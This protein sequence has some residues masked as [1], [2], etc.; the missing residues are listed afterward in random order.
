[1]IFLFGR[2]KK[3]KARPPVPPAPRSAPAPRRTEQDKHAAARADI[4]NT[5]TAERATLPTTHVP[6][7]SVLASVSA[8]AR[9]Q[10]M[11]IVFKD[12]AKSICIAHGFFGY[13][14]LGRH[15]QRIK[16][17][18]ASSAELNRQAGD[19]VKTKE[20]I[21]AL[22]QKAYRLPSAERAKEQHDLLG[23]QN[24][25]QTLTNLH[26]NCGSAERQRVLSRA[27]TEIQML[28]QPDGLMAKLSEVCDRAP[29]CPSAQKQAYNLLVHHAGTLSD[30]HEASTQQ[31]TLRLKHELGLS[32]AVDQVANAAHALLGLS[33]AIPA[34]ERLA[35]CLTS[36]FGDRPLAEAAGGSG[37]A[38]AAL[39]SRDGAMER[40]YAVFGDYLDEHK[41]RAWK[42][43][44]EEPARFYFK[45]VGDDCGHSHVNVHGLNWYLTFLSAGLSFAMPIIPDED[46]QWHYGLVD[47]WA[48]L[49][50][51]AWDYFSDPSNFGKEYT[52]ITA[53]KSGGKG[54]WVAKHVSSDG[55]WPAGQH[56]IKPPRKLRSLIEK[57][58]GSSRPNL[59]L[60]AER[61][62]HFFTRD[63]FV[64]RCFEAL[65]AEMKPEHAGFR[66]A[67]ETL[68]HE[69]R[70]AHGIEDGTLLEHVY[71]DMMTTLDVDAVTL[72][73]GWCGLLRLTPTLEAEL[74]ELKARA[75]AA[76]AA[77]ATTADASTTTAS[78]SSSSSASSA[79][80]AYPSPVEAP[81]RP[82]WANCATSQSSSVRTEDLEDVNLDECPICFECTG[83]VT[84][85]EHME[86]CIGDVSSH[87]M[88][89]SCRHAWCQRGGHVCPFCKE[90]TTANELVGFL[91]QI[92]QRIAS[93]TGDPQASAAVL[94]AIQ[95]FEME[96]EGMPSVIKRVYAMVADDTNLAA[97]LDTAVTNKAEWLRDMAGV[98]WRLD[99]AAKAGELRGVSDGAKARLGRVTAAIWGPLEASKPKE[100]DPHFYGALYSQALVA[101]LCA[102]NSGMAS[103]GL[104][105]VVR[106]CGRVLVRWRQSSP[107]NQ[108]GH[109]QRVGERIHAE[110]L[111]L[112]HQPVWGSRE[113]DPV[114]AAFF[115]K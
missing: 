28:D 22:V 101:W 1:M 69:Y 25:V 81:S 47:F 114:Y 93:S 68:Y 96:H 82:W 38:D 74:R 71:D 90:L 60:Y 7:A 95:L 4:S 80:S 9:E 86:P 110:Y 107:K 49:K 111:A 36:V 84:P 76:K 3:Q 67:A 8:H 52:G 63:F 12:E 106:R 44:F 87:R 59:K 94:E 98:F 18:L 72:F 77:A 105:E 97:Q 66:R 73:L 20:T 115:R 108:S 41:E 39:E 19:G 57:G 91:S 43:A 78:P 113:A 30:R 83:D 109:G 70:I 92:S 16:D 53:L 88:C 61:F 62:A 56:D 54:K 21:V 85:I 34:T 75:D 89:A 102:R 29:R 23:N 64:K 33:S 100:L 6:S 26:Q 42:S 31:A 35:M 46:D 104:A 2:H 79:A 99:E 48:G 55:S 14:S 50:P 45:C 112:S 15:T 10:G 37:G 11:K 103:E 5:A 13:T 32:C 40:L 27:L 65:N 24:V 51:E 58:G 17:I